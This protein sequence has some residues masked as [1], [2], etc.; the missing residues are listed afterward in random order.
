M[1]QDIHIVAEHLQ[2]PNVLP[3]RLA[4]AYSRHY[5]EEGLQPGYINRNYAL[6]TL[7]RELGTPGFPSDCDDRVHLLE[8]GAWNSALAEE[9]G[10]S[11][12]GDHSF[13]HCSLEVLLA[14]DWD[15][16]MAALRWRAVLSA[17][18]ECVSTLPQLDTETLLW[19]AEDDPDL[20]WRECAATFHDD[21]LPSLQRLGRPQDVRI[22]YGFDS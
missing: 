5:R 8:D 16:P 15:A 10:C 20:P 2:A 1:G 21:Y 14:F 17:D 4:P 9:H 18:N 12:L 22:I 11:W 3:W 13:L 7:L 19:W 6:F